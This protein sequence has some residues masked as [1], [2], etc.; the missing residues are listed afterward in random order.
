MNGFVLR[1][2]CKPFRIA[3]ESENRKVVCIW[4]ER[5]TSLA[6]IVAHPTAYSQDQKFS[7]KIR[8]LGLPI[9]DA[10]HFIRELLF[11]LFPVG[12]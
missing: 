1:V 6:Q 12:Q 2:V 7:T 3:A 5:R 10:T 9:R 11:F 8:F 4:W